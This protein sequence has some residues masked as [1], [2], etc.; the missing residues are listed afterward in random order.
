MCASTATISPPACVPSGRNAYAMRC[1]AS[2]NCLNETSVGVS[3][4]SGASTAQG[5]VGLCVAWKSTRPGRTGNEPS[6][7]GAAGLSLAAMLEQ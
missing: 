1:V 7:V 5:R 2:A 6:S 3:P 4:L